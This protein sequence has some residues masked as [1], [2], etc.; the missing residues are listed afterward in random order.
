MT[1]SSSRSSSSA[2]RR[3]TPLAWARRSRSICSV[4]DSSAG[5]GSRRWAGGDHSTRWGGGDH[6]TRGGGAHSARR[7]LGGGSATRLLPYTVPVLSPIDSS[8]ST[9]IVCLVVTTV[10]V[11]RSTPGEPCGGAWCGFGWAPGCGPTR[12]AAGIMVARS[13]CTRSAS[14]W[15]RR[16]ST[17]SCSMSSFSPNALCV[18]RAA[19]V[20]SW[21][22]SSWRTSISSNT[23]SSS[24]PRN[25]SVSR[26]SAIDRPIRTMDRIARTAAT[27]SS[28][29]PRPMSSSSAAS[30]A[31]PTPDQNTPVSS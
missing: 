8:G 18:A 4:H 7:P 23:T 20:M 31:R 1:R 9:T 10:S 13:T 19:W 5:S 27:R 29:P 11:C 15:A 3:P 26:R 30:G 14:T 2:R 22:T 24:S 17:V 6:S 28:R 25:D 21:R 16:A 12:A